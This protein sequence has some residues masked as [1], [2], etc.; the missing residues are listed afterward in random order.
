MGQDETGRDARYG[1]GRDGK[2]KNGTGRDGTGRN[3]R[4]GLGRD[5]TGQDRT[6]RDGTRKGRRGLSGPEWEGM[7]MIGWTGYYRRT[8]RIMTGHERNWQDLRGH[9]QTGPRK[10]QDMTK[11]DQARQDKTGPEWTRLGN[12]RHVRTEQDRKG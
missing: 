6:R 9:D 10:G 5:G 3:T 1:Q 8:G 4:Y 2:G 12:R 11:H 7:V